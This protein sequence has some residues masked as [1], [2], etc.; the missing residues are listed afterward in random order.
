MAVKLVIHGNVAEKQSSSIQEHAH[1]VEK[2]SLSFSLLQKT[3]YKHSSNQH[4]DI[5]FMRPHSSFI[6]VVRQFASGQTLLVKWVA[7]RTGEFVW[8]FQAI[9]GKHESHAR[10]GQI[11]HEHNIFFFCTFL[12]AHDSRFVF[13]SRFVLASH[14]PQFALNAPKD[15][16]CSVG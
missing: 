5:V 12:L 1:W 11:Y 4:L 9:E 15:L 10:R 14:F 7:F 2:D 8:T 13:A 16:T 6:S 3:L